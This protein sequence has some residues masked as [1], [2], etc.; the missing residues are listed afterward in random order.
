[1]VRSPDGKQVT[2]AV[3]PEGCRPGQSFSV[4]F[5]SFQPEQFV[6]DYSTEE[7][8]CVADLDRFFTPNPSIPEVMAI[9]VSDDDDVSEAF[10]VDAR[11]NDNNSIQA[12]EEQREGSDF[13]KEL[14]TKS[15]MNMFVGPNKDDA[16]LNPCPSLGAATAPPRISNSFGECAPFPVSEIDD[17]E[18]VEGQKVLLVRV[19]KGM[20][21]GS[22]VHVEI[23]GENRT[24]AATVPEGVN[25][26]HIFYTPRPLPKFMP[27]QSH[28]LEQA[29]R[30]QLEQA[31]RPE[32]KM[33]PPMSELQQ[34]QQH[35]MRYPTEATVT[36]QQ[37][38]LLVRVPPGTAAGTTIHVSVPDE[39]GRIL[40]AVV[41]AGDVSEFHV[42]YE[43]RIPP[44]NVPTRSFLAPTSPY[45]NPSM[46]DNGLSDGERMDRGG[47]HPYDPYYV[48]AQRYHPNYGYDDEQEYDHGMASF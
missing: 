9:A 17:E 1:M 35:S 48:Q 36:G 39:P 22:T 32:R 33:Q 3:V 21:P 4:T 8:G 18:E 25:S 38:L 28:Q 46:G 37:K 13:K 10:V 20:L 44:S 11:N 40:A 7:A 30:H 31:P 47:Y 12:P 24:V 6:V 29:P 15:L 2:Q 41:P 26:F 14:P 23:P 34:E 27:P 5:P 45:R 43:A 16:A 19:P 42:S